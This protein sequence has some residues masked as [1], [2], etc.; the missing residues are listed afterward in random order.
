VAFL[1]CGRPALFQSCTA[2]SP[3]ARTI[4]SMGNCCSPSEGNFPVGGELSGREFPAGGELMPSGQRHQ[5][6]SGLFATFRI[7][8]CPPGPTA[9]WGMSERPPK[10]T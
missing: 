3:S 8:F 4:L 6:Q 1:A 10:P 7:Q 9:P 5:R 2:Y